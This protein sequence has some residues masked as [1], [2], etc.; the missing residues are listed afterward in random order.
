MQRVKSEVLV[1]VDIF[2]CSGAFELLCTC[3]IIKMT[4]YDVVFAKRKR[5]R[6]HSSYVLIPSNYS[7]MKF[8]L[9]GS[10]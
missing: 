3:K 5:V 1:K 9:G 10:I 4:V 6:R 2:D 7:D 8:K